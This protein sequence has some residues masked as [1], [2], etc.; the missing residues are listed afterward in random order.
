MGSVIRRYA[1]VYI[2]T[3]VEPVQLD[4]PDHPMVL[5]EGFQVP[6]LEHAAQW[7]EEHVC[8]SK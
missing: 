5:V 7:H 4:S 8:T 1:C 2:R 6:F 3:H